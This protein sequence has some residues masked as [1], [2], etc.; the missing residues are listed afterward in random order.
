MNDNII[1]DDIAF[2]RPRSNSEDIDYKLYNNMSK[3]IDVNKLLIHRS[4]KEIHFSAGV[5]KLSI[6]Y[7][8]TIITEIIKKH[9]DEYDSDKN[10]EKLT[11]T[12]IVDSPGG[13]VSAIL[14]FVDF[15]N[16]TRKQYPFLEYVSIITG[17]V[18]SAGT[19]MCVV[20]DRKLMTK[21]A[22]AMIH[23]LSSQSGGKYTH[24]QSY[25]KFL[26]KTHE[27]LAAIYLE[28]GFNGGKKLLE[29]LLKDESWFDAQ[30]YLAHGLIDEIK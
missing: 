13:S 17:T 23:E 30:E 25:S 12:Y 19:I 1:N 24:M 7:L 5:D 11:I 15:I 27:K 21:N 28:N 9:K 10:E 29:E 22:D 18:A 26:E 4:G 8:I 2:N 3:T 14:K 20:A 6:E 16:L